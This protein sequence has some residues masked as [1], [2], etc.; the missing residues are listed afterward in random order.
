MIIGAEFDTKKHTVARSSIRDNVVLCAQY[1]Y[2][3]PPLQYTDW[4]YAQLWLCLVQKHVS[5]INE[6]VFNIIWNVKF[7]TGVHSN[8][9][10]K[11][12]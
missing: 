11:P 8:M 10:S 12:K 9:Y 7:G 3:Y 1:N 2:D 5:I 4:L 6:K